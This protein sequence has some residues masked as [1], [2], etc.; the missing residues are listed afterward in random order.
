MTFWNKLPFGRRTSGQ[1]IEH[2]DTRRQ[3]AA[4]QAARP[5][6]LRDRIKQ[7]EEIVSDEVAEEAVLVSPAEA[8][9]RM[10]NE[11]GSRIW[12]LADGSKTLQEI[13]DQL[14]A[15]YEVSVEQAA[16]DVLAFASELQKAGLI[17][18]V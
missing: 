9:V 16:A 3:Q 1:P 5:L 6:S 15:E 13:A 4:Y 10:L 2:Q 11:V 18:I 8:Q 14:A 17:E 12:A 7:Q